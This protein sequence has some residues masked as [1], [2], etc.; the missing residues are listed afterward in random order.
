MYTFKVNRWDEGRIIFLIYELLKSITERGASFFIAEGF[1][2]CDLITL[3]NY[4]SRLLKLLRD[5]TTVETIDLSVKRSMVDTIWRLLKR[6]F[7]M[8]KKNVME[9]VEINIYC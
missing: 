2:I 8:I 1:L 6:M 4:F 9:I 3:L 5:K 7:L